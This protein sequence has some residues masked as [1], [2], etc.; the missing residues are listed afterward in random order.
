[1]GTTGHFIT[2]IIGTKIAVFAI[3]RHAHTLTVHA[4]SIDKTRR[5]RFTS[6]HVRDMQATQRIVTGIICTRIEV[7]ARHLGRSC[8]D[9]AGVTEVIVGARVFVI[10]KAEMESESAYAAKTFSNRAGVVVITHNRRSFTDASF[11][12]LVFDCAAIIVITSQKR[13]LMDTTFDRVAGIERTDVVVV[14]ILRGTRAHP[15]LRITLVLIR[16]GVVIITDVGIRGVCTTGNLVAPV[17]CA[18]VAVIT[19][20]SGTGLTLACSVT[21]ITG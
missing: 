3:L 21:R 19:S 18:F 7:I 12:A 8:A 20:E 10:A 4:D 5:G 9:M 16:A 14:T 2:Y 13:R 11:I 6:I 1:M 17:N 15:G